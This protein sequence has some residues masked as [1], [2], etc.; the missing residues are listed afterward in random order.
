MTTS[1]QGAK[2]VLLLDPVRNGAHFKPEVRRRG[3]AVVSAYTMPRDHITTRWPE[4]AAGD[5]A[6]F[7]ADGVAE[8][9]HH[10]EGLGVEVTA[11]VAASESAVH[12]GDMLA[13]KLGLTGNDPARS[14]ARRNKAAMRAAALEGGVRIPRFALVKEAS[15]I[16]SAAAEVGFPA[17][18]KHTT[19]GGSHGARLL[20]SAADA[21][22]TSALERRDHFG[23]LVE[24]WL[25]EQYVRGRELAVN[26]F[27]HDGEHQ[28]ID[29]WEYR[30]PDAG[31]YSFPYWELVQLSEDDPDRAR[32]VAYVSEVLTELGVRLG[33][34]H[35][36][37]KVAE[38][39]VY[40]IETGA[41]LP[42]GP[43]TEQWL[44]HSDFD[45]FEQALDCYLGL[46][47]AC[48][49]NPPRF[50]ALSG[51]S[52][53]RNEGPAGRLVEIRGLDELMRRPGVDQVACV[54][55]PG[56]LV[57]VTDSTKNIPLFISLSAPGSQ[58]LLALMA[59]VR[60]TV[61]L[62]IEPV[63]ESV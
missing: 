51:N 63:S 46:R 39:G 40:L 27:S 44:A 9:L 12:L 2:A 38:D 48:L 56:D 23:R 25:V 30:Q 1:L 59:W 5:D 14:L 36:E 4:H 43:L 13:D 28:V 21:A 53:I 42:G 55:T 35:T 15:E 11:V 6:G 57:P 45:P 41:R 60:A 17:I 54:Y 7:Y 24:E 26:C 33:P 37:V 34:S 29:V 22:D 58:E 10:V 62:V 3:L 18:A 47:P 49:D 19:G 32:S 31:D 8:I 61:H 20:N 52:V 50:D 16:A